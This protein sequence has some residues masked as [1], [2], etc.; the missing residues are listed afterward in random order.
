MKQ[1]I[2]QDR[3]IFGKDEKKI[4]ELKVY[5]RDVD[6]PFRSVIELDARKGSNNL[7]R[8]F[9]RRTFSKNPK[10]V[11][12]MEILSDTARGRTV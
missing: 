1:L 9:D 3:I 8:L 5:L 11:E 6:F 10:P 12:L 7:E 2:E 4:P